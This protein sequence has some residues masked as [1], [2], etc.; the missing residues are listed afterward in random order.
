[1][2]LYICER[3]YENILISFQLTERT[4]VHDGN[5][6]VQCSKSNNSKS[7]QTELWFMCS[8]CCLIM[9]YFCVVS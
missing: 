3:F 5:D 7:R 8:A 6:Y 2:E 4:G 9:F 1:M